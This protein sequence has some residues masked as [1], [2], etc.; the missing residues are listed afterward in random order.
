[1]CSLKTK[2]ILCDEFK[3]KF[4]AS[5]V[6]GITASMPV[7]FVSRLQWCGFLAT[8]VAGHI[9]GHFVCTRLHLHRV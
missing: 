2:S 9:A 8:I 5:E 7:D 1:M 6:E 4:Q 3:D